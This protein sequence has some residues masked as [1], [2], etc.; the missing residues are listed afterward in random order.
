[1]GSLQMMHL[2]S[3]CFLTSY[4]LSPFLPSSS[5]LPSLFSSLSV[6]SSN[7][8]SCPYFELCHIQVGVQRTQSNFSP[9]ATVRNQ[10]LSPI[11]PVELTPANHCISEFCSLFNT[12]AWY[13]IQDVIRTDGPYRIRNPGSDIHR[14]AVHR[15]LQL[16]HMDAAASRRQGIS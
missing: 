1:M 14:K 10:G 9:K 5:S 8:N 13:K 16:W 7:K 4:S 3:W 11:T 15:F 2:S 12:G 6:N